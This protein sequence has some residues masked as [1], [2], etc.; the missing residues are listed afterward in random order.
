MLPSLPRIYFSHCKMHTCLLILHGPLQA[1]F[2]SYLKSHRIRVVTFYYKYSWI[3]SSFMI[4]LNKSICYLELSYI[5]IQWEHF[6]LGEQRFLLLLKPM[7]GQVVFSSF[8]KYLLQTMR[9]RERLQERPWV[10][11]VGK[12]LASEWTHL[13]QENQEQFFSRIVGISDLK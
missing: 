3:W 6:L 2:I 12:E 11:R 5:Y 8:R 9:P 10:W 7:H 4:V 1:A 13:F